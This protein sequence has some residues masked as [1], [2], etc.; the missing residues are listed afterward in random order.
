MV[1]LFLAV[2]A[3]NIRII[4]NIGLDFLKTD[5]LFENK[6]RFKVLFR[7]WKERL[8]KIIHFYLGMKA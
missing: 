7:I 5:E 8:F 2:E 4:S 6:F 3:G 1:S